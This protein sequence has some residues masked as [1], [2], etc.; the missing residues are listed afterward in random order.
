MVKSFVA[1]AAV[2]SIAAALSGCSSPVRGFRIYE[3]QCCSAADV[4]TIY[5]PGQIV[6]LH[7]APHPVTAESPR[8]PSNPT[9]S[10]KLYGPYASVNSIKGSATT[11]PGMPLAIAKVLH[12][13]V[14]VAQTSLSSDLLIPAD[15]APGYYSVVMTTTSSSGNSA[16]GATIIQVKTEAESSPTATVTRPSGRRP[17][18]YV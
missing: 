9:I 18:Y 11:P 13:S 8:M 17:V 3:Y 16:G 12:P 14:A 5:S 2:V 1:A 4:D 6:A 7:W 15:A 10:A